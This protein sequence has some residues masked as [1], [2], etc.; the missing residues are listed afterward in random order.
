MCLA[1]PADCPV[2][3]AVQKGEIPGGSYAVFAI[4]HTAEAVQAFWASVGS[5]LGEKGIR[6]DWTRPILERY[7]YRM[8]EAGKCEFCVPVQ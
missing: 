5:V 3:G 1:A 4:P 8:V 2:D 7:R 6:P